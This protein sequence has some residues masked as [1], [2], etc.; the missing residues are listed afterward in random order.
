MKQT[1]GKLT[2]WLKDCA[3]LNKLRCIDLASVLVV[4]SFAFVLSFFA[5]TRSVVIDGHFS[6]FALQL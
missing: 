4:M 6:A 2:Q 1:D 5:W 3:A